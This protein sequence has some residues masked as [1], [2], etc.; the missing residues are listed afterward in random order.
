MIWVIGGMV[1]VAAL[2]ALID[3]WTDAPIQR[4][5]V[6]TG[7][8]RYRASMDWIRTNDESILGIR[9]G[10]GRL[11]DPNAKRLPIPPPD[12]DPKSSV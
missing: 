3:R 5:R 2:F 4:R 7:T 1:V 6:N 11:N 9:I 12:D 8:D 10:S